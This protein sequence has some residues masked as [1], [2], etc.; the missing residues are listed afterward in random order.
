MW[1][2]KIEYERLIQATRDLWAT[3]AEKSVLEARIA[4]QQASADWLM[5]RI[6]SLEI[7]RAALTERVLGIAFPV[8]QIARMNEVPA[9]A[10]E[11][12]GRPVE[13]MAVPPHLAGAMRRMPAM[14]PPAAAERATRP[15]PPDDYDASISALHAAN[16]IFDDP[17]DDA[18]HKAGIGHD[19]LG[20][21]TYAR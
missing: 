7:E 4:A 8:P 18:A 20:N 2:S 14:A 6:N 17:G 3:L 9:G 12:H 1:I 13:E 11:A 19:D 5:A 15:A 16:V 10:V 21:V